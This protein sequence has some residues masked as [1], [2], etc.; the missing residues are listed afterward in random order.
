MVVPTELPSWKELFSDIARSSVSYLGRQDYLHIK[1]NLVLWARSHREEEK[2]L[3][4][5]V[6]PSVRLCPCINA[7][8][9]R[10]SSIK[11]DSGDCNENLLMKSKLYYN[12]EKIS[13]IVHEDL[14]KCYCCCLR[15]QWC[16]ALRIAEGMQIVL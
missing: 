14:N 3:F 9:T 16:Q 2:R 15:V 10:R 11:F 4:P 1:M 12:Q 6:L 7:A 5:H 13:D 8:P